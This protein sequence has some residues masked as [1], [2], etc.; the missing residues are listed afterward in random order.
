M[1]HDAEDVHADCRVSPSQ[2]TS[3]EEGERRKDAQ[4][5]L[6]VTRCLEYLSSGEKRAARQFFPRSVSSRVRSLDP[7]GEG[8]AHP[9]APTWSRSLLRSPS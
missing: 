3:R 9:G 8:R 4:R 1:Q 7:T 5:F 2:Y 6:I